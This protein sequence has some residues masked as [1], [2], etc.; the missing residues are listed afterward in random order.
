MFTLLRHKDHHTIDP[1]NLDQWTFYVL[2]TAELDERENGQHS[3][4]LAALKKLAAPVTFDEL[5]RAVGE[6]RVSCSR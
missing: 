4:S 6:A 5:G 1:L 3:M 2:P